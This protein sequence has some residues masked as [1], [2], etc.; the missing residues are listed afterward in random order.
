[1]ESASLAKTANTL[2]MRM[3]STFLLPT[4]NQIQPPKKKKTKVQAKCSNQT[5]QLR[6]KILKIAYFQKILPIVPYQM[7]RQTLK[8]KE[9]RVIRD[10]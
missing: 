3:N 8:D 5:D 9:E 2:T 7:N 1:V 4:P 6:F 10:Q